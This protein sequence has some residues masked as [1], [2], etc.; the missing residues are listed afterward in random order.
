LAPRDYVLESAGHGRHRGGSAFVGGLDGAI[1]SRDGISW[2]A[3][4]QLSGYRIE[5]VAVDPEDPA[6]I[7][8]SGYAN[9]ELGYASV[10][11]ASV[12]GGA[13]WERRGAGLPA[14]SV[15]YPRWLSADP[16]EPNHL[17]AAF[18]RS[19]VFHSH[20]AGMTWALVNPDWGA[21]RDP[22]ITAF[23]MAPSRPK[24]PVR[25]DSPGWHLSK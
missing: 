6:R 15:L 19:G 7:Y 23:A 16:E 14:V 9:A 24:T 20:D 8:L 25:G 17:Y 21:R 2:E 1:F 18:G 11:L 13:T 12:D 3:V 22:F 4:E 5:A 10:F